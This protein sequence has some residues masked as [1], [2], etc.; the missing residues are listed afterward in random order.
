MK[1][2]IAIVVC[3]LSPFILC[4]IA[5]IFQIRLLNTNAP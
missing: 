5:V 1:P 3:M 2:L 4:L